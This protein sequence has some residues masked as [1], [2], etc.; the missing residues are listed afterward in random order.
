MAGAAC[1]ARRN[2]SRTSD[3]PSPTNMLNA[4]VCVA[5][6]TDVFTARMKRLSFSN[7]HAERLCVCVACS[8]GVFTARI[9]Q[10]SFSN[11]HAERLCVGCVFNR[12]IHCKD[13]ALSI[14]I[15]RVVQFEVRSKVRVRKLS[16]ILTNLKNVIR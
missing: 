6:T 9:K 13:R 12:C 3:S 11:K 1:R 5:C 7:K 10:L 14:V 16:R 2:R 4:C 15:A 8:T